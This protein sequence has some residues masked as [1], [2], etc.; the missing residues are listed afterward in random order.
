MRTFF[1]ALCTSILLAVILIMAGC[2]GGDRD[3]PKAY[4]VPPNFGDSDPYDWSGRTPASYPV[5]GIDVSRWQYSI[6]WQ[7]AANAGVS[8]AWIK[9]TEGGDVFDP[10]FKENLRGAKRAGIPVGAYHFYYH[11]TTAEDQ[12]R[13]FIRNV[14]RRGMTFPPVLDMEYNHASPTCPI[15]PEPAKVRA[16]IR[17]FQRIVGAHYGQRPVIYTTVDFWKANDLGQLAGEE[18]WLRSVAGH[19]SKVYPGAR[20]SFWQYS[21]TGRVPGIE[22]DVDLNAFAGSLEG[23]QAWL[24]R[25]RP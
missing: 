9:A 20:W 4:G 11:C 3:I 8:F 12:A 14:P 10:Y 21:G 24:A 25:R 1:S 23:W 18:F 7:S 5:H 13:W 2:G 19:P 15:R 17:T 22:G 6:D 16:D